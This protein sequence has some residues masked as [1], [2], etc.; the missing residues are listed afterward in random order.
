MPKTR[1]LVVEQV[2][3]SFLV[4]EQSTDQSAIDNARCVAA[5]IEARAVAKL[6][7][8]TGLKA[9]ELVAESARLTVE[10]RQRMIEAHGLLAAIPEQ[11]GLLE[12]FGPSECQPNTN[13]AT[14]APTALIDA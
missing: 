6:P 14:G 11:L 5:M 13:R 8:E 12:F 7:P 3:A 4:A 2:A 9:L 1:M 10:A